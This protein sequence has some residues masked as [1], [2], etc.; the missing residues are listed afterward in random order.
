M[1]K[2]FHYKVFL[3]KTTGEVISAIFQLNK[4]E[5]FYV[6]ANIETKS[7]D[8]TSSFGTSEGILKVFW[9]TFLF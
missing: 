5:S 4:K 9:K 7:T 1:K 2:Q 8:E 6:H 3:S